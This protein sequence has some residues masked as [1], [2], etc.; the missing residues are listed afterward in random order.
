[1]DLTNDRE[2]IAAEWLAPVTDDD[3]DDDIIDDDDDDETF[4][5][6]SPSAIAY[7]LN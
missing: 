3:Y 6:P 2:P 1:M 7:F 4:V 5:I